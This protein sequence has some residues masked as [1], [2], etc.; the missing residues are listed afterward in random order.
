[1][2]RSILPLSVLASILML[3]SCT[4]ND[5]LSADVPV[6]TQIESPVYVGAEVIYQ[7]D[8]TVMKGYMAYDSLATDKKPGIL[9]IHEWWGHN[10]YVRERADKLAELGYVVLAVDMYGEGKKAEHP[11]DAGMFAGEVMSNMDVAKARFEQALATLK[12]NSNVD[13]T[14]IAIVGYCFGGSVAMTMANAGYDIDAVAAFHSGLSLP[15][16]PQEGVKAKYLICNGA[17]D[18]FISAESVTAFKAQMDSVNA[19]YKYIAYE[20]AVHAFTSP[21]ADEM[22]AKFELPLAYNAAADSS[23]WSELQILLK[24]VF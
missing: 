7:T 20:G 3:A 1:M 8:S 12:M 24:S 13:S 19:N 11:K 5:K 4:N 15:I 21:Y 22:G 10:E 16:P 17:A 6:E 23:S 2:S 9:V 18:P 14:K